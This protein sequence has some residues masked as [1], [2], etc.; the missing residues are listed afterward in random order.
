MDGTCDV[1]K[2]CSFG[3]YGDCGMTVP[4]L[5]ATLP[6][7]IG[8]LVCRSKITRMYSLAL[9]GLSIT[10]VVSLAPYSIRRSR[11]Q[12]LLGFR[13]GRQRPLEHLRANRT[14]VA[15]RPV[16]LRSLASHYDAGAS[17]ACLSEFTYW[18]MCACL[19]ASARD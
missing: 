1:P 9:P 10:S 2:H 16:H 8:S 11:L 13:P 4:D 7:A 17:H 18:C 3:D 12:G 14:H 5:N 19:F 15:V 6:D